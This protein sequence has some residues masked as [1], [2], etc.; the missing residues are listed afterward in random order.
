MTQKFFDRLNQELTIRREKHLFREVGLFN[1]Y[2]YNL[3]SND[4]FQLRCHP[5]VI[6]GAINACE[7]FGSGSGASPLLSGFLPCHQDLLDELLSWKQKSFGMLFNSGFVANQAILKHLPSKNDL[8]LVD[9]LIHHSF[10]QALLQCPAH[11]KRYNHLN[12]GELEK[13]LKKCHK[14]YETVF[15]VTE[16]VFSMDGDYPDLNTLV[17]LK[18][19]FPF[20]LILDEAHGTG[21]F[22]DQGGGLAEKMQVLKDVDIIVGTLG[23]AMASMGAYVLSDSK[24]VVDF[25]TNQAG[26]YIYS[27]FLPP[28]QVGAALEAIKL[29]K[30]YNTKREKLHKLSKQLRSGLNELGWEGS[31]YGSP[32]IP[33]IIGDPNETLELRDHFLKNEIL[34]GAVRPPTVPANT[35]RLRVSL[36]SEVDGSFIDEFLKILRLWKK[37]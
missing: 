36:H 27:T 24:P 6:S 34:V 11:F 25:L 37:H 1:N 33:I 8:V 5:K 22:G 18:K 15:V 35:S 12:M 7:K 9:R 28:S 21:V 19:S 13:L 23:K 10:A 31:D 20:V 14:E 17:A 32:I 30:T 29:L 2:R 4:Y 16:S 26:E 3:A